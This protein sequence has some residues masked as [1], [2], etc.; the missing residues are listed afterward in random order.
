[1]DDFTS[2]PEPESSWLEQL[3]CTSREIVAELPEGA[4]LC[5]GRYLVQQELGRGG[6]GIVYAVWDNERE[7]RVALK[8]LTRS[9]PHSI[10]RIKQEFRGLAHVQHPNLV[11][12]HELFEDAGRWCFTLEL[13][14]GQT[15]V[16]GLAGA[17]RAT[18]RAA[19]RQLC[20]GICALHSAG[21]LHRDLKPN[22]VLF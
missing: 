15:L 21:K 10:Y 16:Q 20:D 1:M 7:E 5:A 3:A 9:S 4:E 14:P 2:R 6:M 17:P 8:T 22:N 11:R 13:V 18:V 12:L 19:L